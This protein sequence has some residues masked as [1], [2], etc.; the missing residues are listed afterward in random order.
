MVRISGINTFRNPI[1]TGYVFLEAILSVLPICDEYLVND[2]GSDD[3]TREAIKL[4]QETFPDKIIL[5]DI[6]DYPSDRWHCVSDQY[7]QL[8]NEVS[9]DWIIMGNGDEVIHE[10][11]LQFYK[12]LIEEEDEADVIRHLRRE[13]PRTWD[14][15]SQGE[16][17]ACRTARKIPGLRM[18]WETHG[19]DEF[20]EHLEGQPWTWMRYPPRCRRVERPMW[21]HFLNVFNGNM[22]AKRQNDA[23]YVAQGDTHRVQ[24]YHEIKTWKFHPIIVRNPLDNLPSIMNGL[25]GRFIYEVREEL[26]D[27]DWLNKTTGLEY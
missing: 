6:P 13:V 16:Y 25:V 5:Y 8:I 3:G 12:K 21:W 15:L 2:G 17:G 14:R 7:N 26:F 4:L 19:G 24:I 27:I 1:K 9:G 23:E 22:L 11:D 10:N 18:S 20:I